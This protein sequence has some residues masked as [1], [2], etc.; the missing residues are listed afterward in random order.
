MDLQEGLLSKVRGRLQQP[1][2]FSF[3]F[4]E[5]DEFHYIYGKCVLPFHYGGEIRVLTK[6]FRTTYPSWLENFP[7]IGLCSIC[8]S[9]HIDFGDRIVMVNNME[10]SHCGC[11]ETCKFVQMRFVIDYTQLNN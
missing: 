5:N 9:G 2:R 1:I 3:N 7:A 10:I 6:D 8:G 4:S 11:S